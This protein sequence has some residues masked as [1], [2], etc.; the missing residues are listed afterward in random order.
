MT[1]H[2]DGQPPPPAERRAPIPSTASVSVSGVYASFW[3]RTLAL[4]VNAVIVRPA[5]FVY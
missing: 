5:V 1:P 3:W 2:P 4:V